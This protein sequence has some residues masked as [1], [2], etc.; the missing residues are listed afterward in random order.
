[1]RSSERDQRLL[2]ASVARTRDYTVAVFPAEVDLANACDIRTS[3]L[4]LLNDR[5]HRS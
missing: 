3:L 1:M 2:V 4:Q 5:G